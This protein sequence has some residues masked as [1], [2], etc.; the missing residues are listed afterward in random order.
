MPC[1]L[2]QLTPSI[3]SLVR[4]FFASPWSSENKRPVR[5]CWYFGDGT[6]TV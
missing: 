2:F 4:G 6:D 1:E 5:V 3:T